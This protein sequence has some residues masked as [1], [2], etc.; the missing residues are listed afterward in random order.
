MDFRLSR[1]DTSWHYPSG[2][3]EVTVESCPYRLLRAECS[4][5]GRPNQVGR[6]FFPR[7]WPVCLST[8]LV[9]SFVAILS[10][11]GRPSG[12]VRDSRETISVARKRPVPGIDLYLLIDD[13]GSMFGPRGTDP[14]GLRFEASKYLVQNLLVKKADPQAPN[15]IAVLHFGDA[16][17]SDGMHDL[18]VGEVGRITKAIGLPGESHLGDTNFVA[19][20]RQVQELN[21]HA[22]SRDAGRRKIVVVFTDGEPDDRRKLSLQSYFSEIQAFATDSLKGFEL[23][24][25][26][27]DSP[28]GKVKFSETTPDW[29][30]IAGGESVF[31]LA[32]VQDLYSRFNEAVRRIFELPAIEPVTVSKQEEFE[33][34]PYLDKLE[35]HGFTDSKV[36]VA[37]RRPDGTLAK[38]GDPGLTLRKEEGYFILALDEP[39][40]GKWRYE[41]TEG[42]G[43]VRILRN[44]IP[45]R[46]R[47][48]HPP[49]AYPL[50]KPL[51]LRAIFTKENGDEVREL[52]DYPLSFTAKVVSAEEGSFEEDARFLPD[53]K[54][55]K[56][57]YADSPIKLPKAGRY[58]VH[59]RVKGGMRVESSSTERVFVQAFPYLSPVSPGFLSVLPLGKRL[60]VEIRLEREG[61]PTNPSTEFLDNPND[62]ILAQI[63]STPLGMR[64]PAVWLDHTGSGVYKA[65][66]PVDRIP[67]DYSLALRI[68]GQPRIANQ[69]VPAESVETV[70]FRVSPSSTQRWAASVTK[71]AAW[72]GPVLLVWVVF[73][74]FWLTA[75]SGRFTGTLD[76]SVGGSEWMAGAQDRF[77]YAWPKAFTVE[78]RVEQDETDE[79][80]GR[81]KPVS[82]RK[83]SVKAW[84]RASAENA[85]TVHAGGWWSL[86]TLGAFHQ[87]CRAT[88]EDGDIE[89]ESYIKGKLG[90]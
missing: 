37:V 74:V 46:L 61:K 44:P 83:R 62:L 12:P 51:L 45:F 26:G 85:V 59:L 55:G 19:A 31:V 13:S 24:V 77:R 69:L 22:P 87:K 29:K 48:S 43:S 66:I 76:L 79:S 54:I 23:F 30:R 28:S 33:V 21:R 17:Q 56:I 81:V 80:S 50:G 63:V 27:I 34:L 41:I 89:I 36:T 90:D 68:K 82:A 78:E 39:V 7:H 3:E 86:L 58:D 73:V 71:I 65:S 60:D 4:S 1:L 72:G 47:L 53:R 67:G 25:I 9:G 35:I 57:Y 40:P 52:P 6:R 64:S 18:I 38:A 16:S 75:L 49:A 20:F 84:L 10:A 14:K 15:R 42:H 88:K 2:A 5:H 11:C 32:D 70:E 8:V